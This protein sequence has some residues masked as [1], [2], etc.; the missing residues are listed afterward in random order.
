[1]TLRAAVYVRL[2]EET[3]TTTSPARQ[4]EIC[5]IYAEARGWSLVGFFEDID[6]SAS[7]SRLDR[8]GLH[9]LGAAID[10]GEVDVVL[11]WRLDRLARKVLDLLTLLDRWAAEEV[12]VVSATEGVDMTTPAGKAMGALIGIFAELEAEAI[13]ARVASSVDALRRSGRYSG[14]VVPYGYLPAPNPSGPGS[15]LVVDP[16][17]KAVVDEILSRVAAGDSLTSISLDLGRRGIPAPRSEARRLSR[18]GRPDASADRGRWLTTTLSRMIRRDTLL[19]RQLHRGEPIRDAHGLP[20]EVWPPVA[21]RAAVE[22]A[23]RALRPPAVPSG[24][25]R[26]RA[27][28]LSSLALCAA[29]GRPLHVGS[30]GTLVT[31][32]CYARAVGRSCPSPA[33]S[34]LP[35]EDLVISE[36]LSRVGTRPITETVVE[37]SPA[38]AEVRSALAEVEEGLRE[39]ATALSGDDADVPDLVARLGR[40]KALRASLRAQAEASSSFAVVRDT[41]RTWA[42]DWHALDPDDLVRRRALLAAEVDAVLVAPAPGRNRFSGDRVRIV[43]SAD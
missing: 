3:E 12:A 21:S 40:L 7:R 35:L 19:G 31:Y 43:W 2:S 42:D 14:G 15:V 4:R 27:R 34:A 13:R 32:R 23:R 16:E 20:A 39:A 17:E 41:G 10:A 30:T 5:Q 1:M 38:S 25:R 33:I 6:V 28:L 22:A 24:T 8:P 11:V 9:R 37:E 26:R 29:C 36:A 18:Q